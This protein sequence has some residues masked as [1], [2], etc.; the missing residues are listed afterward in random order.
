[1]RARGRGVVG[2]RRAAARADGA[3]HR[4]R[5]R[6][7]HADLLVLRDRRRDRRGLARGRCSWTSI[8]S[9]FNIDPA[10]I[11][12]GHHAAHEGDP[13]GAPV[14]PE[15]RHGSD[16]RRR[17]R[18]PASRSSR[19]PRRRSARPTRSRPV[20]G[21][22]ALGCF[23]FF[24]SKNLGAFG[25]AG[26]VTTNDAALAAARAA[27]ARRTAWSRS[28]TTTSSAATSGWTRCR[29]RCCASRR[30]TWRRG[31]RRG[32]LNASRYR[33]LFRDAGLAR[34]RRRC[35]S[36]RR[37]G[38]TS[39]ISSS[40]A[41]PIAT[42]LKR[43]LDARGIGN[44]IYYPVPFHLQPC[45]ADLGYRAGDF[46]ARRARGRREPGASDLRRADARRS[47]RPSST[48]SPSSSATSARGRRPAG[49]A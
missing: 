48:R 32:A 47:S 14:R 10:A 4:G 9:T 20:G 13:A 31:P 7:R 37:T 19:T 28:T 38:A 11:A 25:D 16:R 39:S 30:R 35:R 6:G 3:R 29:R 33:R 34:P 45:F 42:A 1:M 44:E 40:S 26:L 22:G 15:R 23:S 24:P 21:I 8:R 49:D 18:A 41:S 36:S 5:R 12:R 43:H 46:P 17:R 2:H 27:A